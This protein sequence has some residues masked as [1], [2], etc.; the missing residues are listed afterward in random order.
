MRNALKKMVGL[1]AAVLALVVAA[2][3]CQA[4]VIANLSLT[5]DQGAKTWKAYLTLSD[6]SSETLGLNGIYL[7]V[8]GSG[9]QYGPWTGV[10]VVDS[11]TNDLP[12]GFHSSVGVIGF[13]VNDALTPTGTGFTLS[14]SMQSNLHKEKLSGGTTYN[15]ILKGV[16]K[17]SGSAPPG[18]T[19]EYPVL[20]AEGTYTGYLGW[21]N[22]SVR[23]DENPLSP[24]F[25]QATSVTVLP[26]PLIAPTT[27]GAAFTTFSPMTG[28]DYRAS[29]FVP[30]PATQTLLALGGLG[31]LRRKRR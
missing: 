23:K 26:N 7:D 27:G 20:V 12:L 5:V 24:T 4:S 3:A 14:G 30:E 1:G 25:G 17:T 8:W 10:L 29:F 16:G 9:T 28:D 22:V 31:V 18:I 11:I 19:W 2:G 21:L 13:G 6:P 15:N